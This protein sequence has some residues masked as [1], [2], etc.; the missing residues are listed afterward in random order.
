MII[1]D[2]SITVDFQERNPERGIKRNPFTGHNE[3]KG[4]KSIEGAKYEATKIAYCLEHN[5]RETGRQHYSHEATISFDADL[6]E[7]DHSRIWGQICRCLRANKII[8]YWHRELCETGRIHYHLLIVN[9]WQQE[10]I[11]NTLRDSLSSELK[12]VSRIHCAAIE[13][14]KAL[15]QYIPKAVVYGQ[16]IRASQNINDPSYGRTSEDIYFHKRRIFKKECRLK[17]CGSIGEFWLTPQKKIWQELIDRQKR[18]DEYSPMMRPEA[19]RLARIIDDTGTFPLTFKSVHR[20]LCILAYEID[21][22]SRQ[23]SSSTPPEIVKQY[24]D[25]KQK[26]KEW[27]AKIKGEPETFFDFGEFTFEYEGEVITEQSDVITSNGERSEKKFLD[28][29]E[30]MAEHDGIIRSHRPG[31]LSEDT[32][33][34]KKMYLSG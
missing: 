5:A 2:S 6:T 9:K 11:K 17:K 30:S 3:A 25:R 18:I 33:L 7:N 32:T 12:S 34:Q 31:L 23:F 27:L 24:E 21:K 10:E 20:H 8:A 26:Q 29:H 4:W 15:C 13:D 16:D 22:P 19:R 14:Q 1:Y 28:H